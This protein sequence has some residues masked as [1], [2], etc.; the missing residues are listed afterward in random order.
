VDKSLVVA[1]RGRGSAE[2]YRLLETMR[3][4][5]EER[6][7]EVDEAVTTRD[8]HAAWYMEWVERAVPAAEGP[9]QVVWCRRFDEELDNIRAAMDWSVRIPAGVETALRLGTAL[10]FYWD[11]RGYLAE[12]R[13]RLDTALAL[14]EGASKR[15]RGNALRMSGFMAF[16]LGDHARA[17]QC[18]DECI[19]LLR[20]AGEPRLLPRTLA[21]TGNARVLSDAGDAQGLALLEEALKPATELGDA[22]AIG[23]ANFGFGHLAAQRGDLSGAVEF[24]EASLAAARNTGSPWGIALPLFRLGHLALSRGDTAQAVL[25]L[26]ESLAV[27]AGAD[28]RRGVALSLEVLGWASSAARRLPEAV[29]LLSAA[30]RLRQNSGLTLPEY[31]LPGHDQTVSALRTGLGEKSFAIAWAEGRAMPSEEYV[32]GVL[33]S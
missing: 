26:R 31:L 11:L 2:R 1:E 27:R 14:S 5:G 25:L 13:R 15:T 6:L 12:G 4:Y 21:F 3:Q 10:W 22:Q 28:D 17:R 9:L 23:Y 32:A 18:F 24:F 8:R 20:Q 19:P 29:R 7:L 16:L 33:A 30:D